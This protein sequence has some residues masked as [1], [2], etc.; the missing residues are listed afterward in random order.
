MSY[1]QFRGLRTTERHRARRDLVGEA[2]SAMDCDRCALL[3]GDIATSGYLY[4]Y[5]CIMYV[6]SSI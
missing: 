1:S 2:P 6:Y 3:V 5:T 4:L